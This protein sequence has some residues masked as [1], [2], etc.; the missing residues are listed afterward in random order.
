MKAYQKEWVDKLSTTSDHDV[1]LEVIREINADDS[2]CVD[3][4]AWTLAE[5][6]EDAIG[7]IW[8]LTQ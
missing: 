2:G 4:L 1:I 6:L 8:S 7:L 5:K 3:E